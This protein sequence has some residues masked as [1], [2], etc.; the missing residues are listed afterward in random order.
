M[1]TSRALVQELGR[2]PTSEEIAK[3]MDIPVPKVRNVLKIAQEAISLETPIGENDSHLGDFI[4]DR[5]VM[6]PA[7]AVITVA[8]QAQTESVLKTLTPREEQV[9]K[10]RFGVGDG[11]ERTLEEVGQRFGVTRE[12]I[13]QIEVKAL[14]KLRHASRSRKLRAFLEGR[15]S[16]ND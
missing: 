5:Q 13:R 10:M 9:I 6:S 3:Q 15:T 12:R 11:R 2:K 4:E 14:H 8:L 1:R 16:W 7:D